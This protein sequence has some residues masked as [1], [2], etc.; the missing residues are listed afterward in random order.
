MIIRE[1]WATMPVLM[2]MLVCRSRGL[3]QEMA[4]QMLVYSFGK[5]VTQKLRFPELQNRIQDAVNQA[6]ASAP[7]ASLHDQ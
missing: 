6:L 2:H 7:V 5:E 1:Y 4:R 3:D